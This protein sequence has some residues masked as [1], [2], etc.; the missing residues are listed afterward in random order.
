MHTDAVDRFLHAPAT[1]A[2]LTRLYG[3]QDLPAQ[4]RRYRALVQGYVQAFGPGPCAL[5]SAPGR[6]EILGNHTDHNGGRVLAASIQLD[7]IAAAAPNNSRQVVVQSATY[8]ERIAVRLDELAPVPEDTGSAALVKGVLAGFSAMGYPLGGCNVYTTS[9]VPPAAGVSSSASFEMLLCRVFDTLFGAGELDP[10]ACA[11][12]GQYAEHLYW[13]KASG[14]LDQMACAVGG[15]IALDFADPA[16]PTYAQVPDP[17]A[18][19]DL[20]PVI[21]STGAGHG[22]LSEAYSAVPREMGQA[23]A[24]LGA[25]RLGELTLEQVYNQAPALRRGAGDRALLRALHFFTENQRVDRALAAIAAGDRAALLAAINASGSSSWRWL[26]NC[27]NPAQPQHQQVACALALTEVF[28]SG[29]GDGACRVHGGGFAGVILAVVPS[30]RLAAYTESMDRLLGP[31][32]CQQ[33]R[34]RPLGA[35][36]L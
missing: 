23:A 11:Q 22:D 25:E 5:F 21:V 29:I 35:I 18:A 32:R 16:R 4:R 1:E 17:F 33:L 28:L 27:A 7:C 19:M 12:I 8:H 26:Q 13:D 30:A 2:L 14:L 9:Q 10:T 31:G 20:T 24:L 34:I 6:A 3:E 15:L 36:A